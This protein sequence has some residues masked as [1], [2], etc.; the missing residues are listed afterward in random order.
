VPSGQDEFRRLRAVKTA[1]LHGPSKRSGQPSIGFLAVGNFCPARDNLPSPALFSFG[2]RSA[3]AAVVACDPIL[4][5][6]THAA[7]STH[8]NCDSQRVKVPAG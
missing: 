1:L 2:S 6:N 8:C 3:T 5:K 4:R 7:D